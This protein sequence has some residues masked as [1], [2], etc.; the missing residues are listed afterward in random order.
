M[1]NGHLIDSK[2]Q[3]KNVKNTECTLLSFKLLNNSVLKQ[4]IRYTGEED[5]LYLCTYIYI[6]LLK[7]DQYAINN[8]IVKDAKNNTSSASENRAVNIL[9]ISL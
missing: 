9:K 2:V 7:M 5:A 8:E 4:I 1:T 3:Y 6:K